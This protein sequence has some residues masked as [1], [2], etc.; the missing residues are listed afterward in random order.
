MGEAAGEVGQIAADPTDGEVARQ[1]LMLLAA[2]ERFSEAIEAMLNG[3]AAERM[4]FGPV[5]LTLLSTGQHRRVPLRIRK[6]RLPCRRAPGNDTGDVAGRFSILIPV[7]PACCPR[8]YLSNVN[9]N[10]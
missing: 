5:G 1:A 7:P 3:P 8:G 6:T 4:A 2:D 10:D 9:G